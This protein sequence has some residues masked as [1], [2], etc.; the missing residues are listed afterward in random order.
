MPTTSAAP[1]SPVERP[2]V[3]RRALLIAAVAVPLA[4]VAALLA[5]LLTALIGLVTNLAFHGRISPEFSSPAGHALGAAV[6]LVPIVG[7]VIVGILARY[8]HPSIRGHGIPE[9]MERILLA[10]SRI[11]PRVTVLKPVAT[12]IA[13]GTGGPFGAEGPI[14]ASGGALGSLAGQFLRVSP[15]ER[16]ALLAAGAAAGMTATFGTPVAATLLAIELLLF[17]Y[18]ARS[19]VVVVTATSVAAAVRLARHGAAPVFPIPGLLTMPGGWELAAYTVI[20]ALVGLAAVLITRA[21]YRV[22]DGFERLGLHWMWWPALGGIV[23]GLV[24]WV[25]PRTLGV[26]YDNIEAILAGGFTGGALA[27]LVGLKLVSW[28]VALGSGTAG[29]TLAP[30]FTIGGGLG[31]LLGSGTA[32]LVPALG[33]DPRVA[34]LVGMAAIFTGASRALLTSVVFAFEVTRQPLGLLPLLAGS[35]AAYLLSH[36][37]MRTTIMTERLDRRGVHVVTE[38][39]A[40]YL[41][42]EAVGDHATGALVTLRA[43]RTVGD[44][45]AWLAAGADGATHQGFPVVDAGGRLVGLLTRRD[46]LAPEAEPAAPLLRLLRRPPVVVY[47]RHSLRQA[48]DLMVRQGV[49]RVAVVEEADPGRLLGIITRS[50]L[51]AAHARRL[52]ARTADEPRYGGGLFSRTGRG[53]S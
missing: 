31:A 19:L 41:S 17:E 51:L 8:G 11:S 44:A 50:D 25:E 9:V 42:R 7:G 26:G 49:G 24:G 33:V 46:L 2:P 32:A 40:D 39:E 1:V 37:R 14:I 48:A 35:T 30:L 52:A 43:D 47:P 5:D 45:R 28:L 29:G 27:A 16:K 18:R 53:R 22:E 13:I 15:N 38:Y 20:G 36:F 4:L 34:A 3:D 12:A 6:V 23:V 21:L 10:D